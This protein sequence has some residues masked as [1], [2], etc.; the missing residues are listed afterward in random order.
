MILW[1]FAY[2]LFTIVFTIQIVVAASTILGRSSSW[3]STDT[4]VVD[5]KNGNE[6]TTATA[7]AVV[8]VDSENYDENYE[9]LGHHW[10]SS[11]HRLRASIMLGVT[12][13]LSIFMFLCFGLVK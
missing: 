11:D 3:T 6:T 5:S 8:S 7:T 13:S 10:V 12:F 1:S 9:D 2:H 4:S